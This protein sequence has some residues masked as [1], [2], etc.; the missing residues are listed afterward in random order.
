VLLYL[1]CTGAEEQVEGVLQ[2]DELLTDDDNKNVELDTSAVDAVDDNNK[3]VELE[4][5]TSALDTVD[6]DNDEF[7]EWNEGDGNF[8]AS[9]C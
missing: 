3:N 6:D 2:S 8:V 9:C 7:V 5:D 4:L 1:T